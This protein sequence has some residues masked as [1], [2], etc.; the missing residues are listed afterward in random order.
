MLQTYK[1]NFFNTQKT[2]Y[3]ERGI[4]QGR[5]DMNFIFEWQII[6]FATRK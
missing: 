3:I 1:F 4:T 6:V 2:H 5:E